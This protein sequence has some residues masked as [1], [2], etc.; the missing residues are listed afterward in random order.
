MRDPSVAAAQRQHIITE[1]SRRRDPAAVGAG[2]DR[3][4]RDPIQ[5]L[6]REDHILVREDYVDRVVEV[7]RRPRGPVPE[8]GFVA[9]EEPPHSSVIRGD[10]LVPL[11]GRWDALEILDVIRDEIGYGVASLDHVV[12]ITP[13]AGHCPATE[14]MPVPEGCA[15]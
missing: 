8:G 2:P 5:Y 14:P 11:S 12:S 10:R 4:G 1:F 6:F 7:V 3:E 9:A 13:E 15:P